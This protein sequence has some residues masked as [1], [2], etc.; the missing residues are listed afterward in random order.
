MRERV[1]AVVET[2]CCTLA[3]ITVLLSHKLTFR[4]SESLAVLEDWTTCSIGWKDSMKAGDDE[5][6]A[7]TVSMRRSAVDSKSAFDCSLSDDSMVARS[8][9]SAGILV[10]VMGKVLLAAGATRSG[11]GTDGLSLRRGSKA[12]MDPARKLMAS[13]RNRFDSDSNW[14]L[15]LILFIQESRTWTSREHNIK[16]EAISEVCL[17]LP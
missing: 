5:Y 11:K 17:I 8:A 7:A 4:A 14:I 13:G 10:V 16:P 2:R 12:T 15:A 1:L 9:S 3:L 6:R